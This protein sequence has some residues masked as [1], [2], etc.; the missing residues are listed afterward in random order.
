VRRRT[1]WTRP[2]GWPRLVVAAGAVGGLALSACGTSTPGTSSA[3]SPSTSSTTAP[4]VTTTS[5]STGDAATVTSPGPINPAAVPLGDGY[6]STTPKVG[7]V[8]S[9]Q[10][11]GGTGG[12]AVGGAQVD[13]PWINLKTK[14]WNSLTKLSVEGSVAWPAASYSVTVA[15]GRRIIK[16]NDL[17]TGHTTGVFPISSSDPAYAYDHNPNSIEAQ[18]IDW[19]L[20]ENPVA[21]AAPSCTPGGAIGVLDDGVLLFNA[22]DGE[23]RDAGAHEV[24]DSCGEH[25]QMGDMLHHHA[26]PSCILSR[27]TGTSTLVGFAIDGYG[28]YV[29]RD[30]GGALLTNTDLDACH[31]RTSTVLWNGRE[32]S[33]YHYDA[34]LEYPYTVGCFHGT[35]IST[36]AMG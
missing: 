11:F 32:Q 2:T 20:P 35:P 28:I 14:T 21:A 36:G 33:V 30:A 4:A 19:S 6:L 29:E 9:C 8:D 18:S 12:S 25:P 13:G 27:A 31:G 3:P 16:T 7:Y 1:G 34:T 26:V 10:T 22:L 5:G 15:G 17:P 23:G 24:L